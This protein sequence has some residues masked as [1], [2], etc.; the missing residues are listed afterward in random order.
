MGSIGVSPI[1][2][3]YYNAMVLAW[4]GAVEKYNKDV[5]RGLHEKTKQTY[6]NSDKPQ[7]TSTKR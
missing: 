7:C 1:K 5:V 4:Q 3:L 2:C 6:S